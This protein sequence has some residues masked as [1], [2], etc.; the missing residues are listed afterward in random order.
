VEEKSGE[1]VAHGIWKARQ[2]KTTRMRRKFI[3]ICEPRSMRSRPT[4]MFMEDIEKDEDYDQQLY[5]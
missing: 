1:V 2:K 4:A 3:M 5:A